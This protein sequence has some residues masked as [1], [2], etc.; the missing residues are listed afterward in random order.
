MSGRNWI[1]L[2]SGAGVLTLVILSIIY[3]S[4]RTGERAPRQETGRSASKSSPGIPVI[5]YE[6]ASG[7]H[8]Y[9]RYCKVC[10]GDT[11]EGDGFNAFNLNPKPQNF[12]DS[13][14]QKA[15]TDLDLRLAISEGGAA[16]RRSTLM[17]AWGRVLGQRQTEH[18]LKC[19]RSLGQALP[20]EE[21]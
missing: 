19:V 4:V 18:V 10:H 1:Y 21:R 20:N 2:L 9:G 13:E 5:S 17:P 7:T 14:W 11:G 16:V 3:Q 8:V 12:K 15:T 6:E